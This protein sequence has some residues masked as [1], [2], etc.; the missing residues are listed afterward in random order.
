MT[1]APADPSP[2]A[3]FF[4]RCS[5][6][7]AMLLVG[8]SVVAAKFIVESFPITLALGIRQTSA[9]VILLGILLAVEGRIPRPSRRVHGIVFLQNLTGV[10]L[11]NTL[12]MLGVSMTTAAASGIIT[13]TVPAMI[14]LFSRFLG[15]RISR[16]TI[17][18]IALAMG[19]VIIV[20]IASA[21]AESA[22]ASRPL[23]GGFLVLVAV[24][25]E[26]LFTIFGKAV[27]GRLTPIG[28]CF[29][30]CV[31]GSLMFA[32]IAIWQW[33]GFDAGAVTSSGW[34]A[35][36][37]STGPVMIG[38][39]FLWFSGL[40]VIPAN[41]AAIYTGLIPVSALGCSALLL[42]EHIG[43]PHMIGMACVVVAV[44]LVARPPVS[45]TV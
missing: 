32:P 10:V 14:A 22:V 18:G 30:V 5:L 3:I 27:G 2:R 35:L 23:L 40:R 16:L 9:A 36:A 43:W 11:F 29:L 37:W 21:G 17:G 8:S 45:S 7:L 26:A 28:N 39:F 25:A 1:L 42:G 20:N 41:N 12:L 44:V 4:A 24:M 6:A 13:S 33:P 34:L 19:G 38:G 15:E 31:Y